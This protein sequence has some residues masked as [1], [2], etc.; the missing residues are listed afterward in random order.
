M[1][2]TVLAVAAIVALGVSAPTAAEAH[3]SPHIPGWANKPCKSEDSVNCY[4]D[5]HTMGN[6]QGHSYIVRQFPGY[7]KLVCVMYVKK[8]DRH[9]DYCERT[10]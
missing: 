4:W 6:G 1:K 9:M 3:K 8:A 10:R 2:K 5:A 7:V